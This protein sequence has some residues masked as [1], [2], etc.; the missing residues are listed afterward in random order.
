MLDDFELRDDKSGLTSV[1]LKTPERFEE[2]V[3]YQSL[4]AR[5]HSFHER[6]F[7]GLNLFFLKVRPQAMHPRPRMIS[8]VLMSLGV[9]NI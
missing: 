9:L 6:V 3:R 7:C 2:K 5:T 8:T 1:A 4:Q